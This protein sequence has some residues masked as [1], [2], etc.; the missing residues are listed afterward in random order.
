V[1][2]YFIRQGD[3]TDGAVKIGD[4][5]AHHLLRVLRYHPGDSL[6][7]IDETRKK[8]QA[9][10]MTIGSR[11]LS[12][13]VL[14]EEQQIIRPPQ[15]RLGMALRKGK[16]MDWVIEK[17]TELGVARIS[18]LY[19]RRVVVKSE[20]H[21]GDHQQRRWGEI[22]KEAAQQSER[23]DIPTI[24]LP[25]TFDFFLEQTQSSD[26]K[27][28]CWEAE[29]SSVAMGQ[30]GQSDGHSLTNASI[31]IGPEGGWDTEEVDI[32]RRQGYRSISLGDRPLRADTAA[33][34]ALAILQYEQRRGSPA[35]RPYET[36]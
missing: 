16:R 17:A 21:R 9:R 24:D 15:M 19:T 27:L 33:I 26:L 22:A 30:M 5:L 34:T 3:V 23:W 6:T 4:P 31:L 35:G 10:I 13:Q 18:P 2:F 7:L 28:I 14:S 8:Y 25:V 29:A 12:L 11:S 32:A 36:I 20:A 1:P